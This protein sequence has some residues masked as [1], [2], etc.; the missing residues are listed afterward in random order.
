MAQQVKA[1]LLQAQNLSLITGT[2]IKSQ[3]VAC[4]CNPRPGTQREV[5]EREKWPEMRAGYPGVLS[6]ATE[7][8]ETLPQKGRREPAPKGCPPTSTMPWL[9]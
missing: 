8:R 5:L 1:L 2:H 6:T 7:T 3:T 9:T 4:I